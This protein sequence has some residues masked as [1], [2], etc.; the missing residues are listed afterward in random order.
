MKSSSRRETK[1][2]FAPGQGNWVS[3]HREN[4]AQCEG[5]RD[6]L[7]VVKRGEMRWPEV[8]GWRKELHL[9]F[10]LALAETNLPEQPDYEGANGFLIR[11]RKQMASATERLWIEH[12]ARILK[13]NGNS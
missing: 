11:A 12:Q 4:R 1:R 8:D 10:E 5:V 9:D 13:Q 2:R 3:N 7:Q 6:G